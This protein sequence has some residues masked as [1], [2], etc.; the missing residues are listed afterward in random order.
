MKMK[1]KTKTI[2]HPVH[3]GNA[4]FVRTVTN[5]LVGRIVLL[6]KESFVLDDA[7]WVAWPDDDHAVVLGGRLSNTQKYPHPVAVYRGAC[8]DVTS[9]PHPLP[10][11]SIK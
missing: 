4:V 2:Q 9:W 10:K 1:T 8:V 6:D 3:I 7:S 5:H 11:D